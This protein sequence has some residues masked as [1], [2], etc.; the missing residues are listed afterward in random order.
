M[1]AEQQTGVAPPP[2]TESE[3]YASEQSAPT[4]EETRE[5]GAFKYG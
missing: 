3:R 4:E 2:Q 5:A 1:T